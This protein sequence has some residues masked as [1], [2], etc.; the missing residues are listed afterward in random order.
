MVGKLDNVVQFG[1]KCGKEI[2]GFLNEARVRSKKTEE[3]YRGDINRYLKT[4]YNSD[5]DSITVEELDS[6]SF[7]NFAKYR[8]SF[9]NV[10]NAT[11]NRY[12][13]S[14][15]ALY[16]NLRYRNI[17][18]SD[19]SYFEL[20][21]SLNNDSVEIEHMPL[22]IVLEYME[23]AKKSR[24]NGKVK[25]QLIHLAADQ[26]LRLEE[27]LELTWKNFI[28]QED[29]VAIKTYGKGNSEV[30]GKMGF[31]VYEKILV[32]KGDRCSSSKVFAPLSSK[33]IR[34]MMADIKKKLGYDDISYSFHSLR[35]SAT[36][37]AFRQTGDILEA[38]RV[39]GHED[40]RTTQIYIKKIDYGVMGMFSLANHD[41]EAYKKLTHEELLATLENMNKDMLHLLNIKAG[42]E[43]RDRE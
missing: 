28:P 16:K 42:E 6:M 20:V 41:N 37:F 43:L 9:K 5:I 24:F 29:G 7:E 11:I 40:L 38:Q 13:S 3:N 32:L 18:K 22:S 33:V 4:V 12:T 8:D 36:T 14:I 39:A 15:R 27:L 23:E 2:E 1:T 25:E 10:K 34:T 30:L 26:G 35:K 19:I 17:L 21:S 31:N